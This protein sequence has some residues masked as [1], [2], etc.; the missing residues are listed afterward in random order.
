MITP[1]PIQQHERTVIVDI[2]RGFALSGVLIANFTAYNQQNLPSS[3]FDAIS[4]PLDRALDEFNSVF[5]EW[6]FMTLFSILFGY[7]FGLIIS[8]LE[9]KNI[10]PT[11]FFARRMF[12]LFVFGIIHTLFWWADVLHLYAMSGIFL[13]LFR[14]V[15][16]Q[17]ILISSLLLMFVLPAFISFLFRGHPDYFTESNMQLLYKQYKYGNLLDVFSANANLYYKAF[18]ITGADLHDVIETLG[19]FLFGYFLLRINLFES[20]ANKKALFRK[21]LL[22]TAPI[23]IAYF[24]IRW[25]SL[26]G[27]IHTSGIIWEP[28]IKIGIVATSTF[29]TSVLVLLFSAYGRIRLFAW[30]QALGKMTLTNYLLI[31]AIL[32]IV[33]YGIGFGKLGE[34]PM[35]IVWPWALIWLIIEIVFSTT[36]LRHFRFGPFEWIWRQLTY[37]KWIPIRNA[38]QVQTRKSI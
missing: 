13:L 32:I 36:W 31:S 11:S 38:P 37:K 23:V 29:Y 18:V 7:G 35:H 9:K 27:S 33:L 30:L 21:V 19:R 25:L 24:I 15:S 5:F 28:L 16:V 17:K 34:I 12:W 4:S 3:V 8:S 22:V 26:K 6:K 14:K 2:I 10:D 1:T 20:V